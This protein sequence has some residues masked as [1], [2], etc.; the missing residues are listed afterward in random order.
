ML[1]FLFFF[2]IIICKISFTLSISTQD[3]FTFCD[4]NS[5]TLI[6]ISSS[7]KKANSFNNLFEMNT[8]LG[9]SKIHIFDQAKHLISGVAHEC[10]IT[11]TSV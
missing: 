11:K 8:N 6:V 4:P 7:C 1:N 3:Y 9:K 2:L 10:S 5:R